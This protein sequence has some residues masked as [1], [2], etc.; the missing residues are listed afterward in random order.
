MR[1]ASPEVDSVIQPPEAPLDWIVLKIAQRCNLNCTYCYVYNRG[2]DSWK[3]RPPIISD[4]VVAALGR[5]I[6][7]QCEKY[8]LHRFV[9]EFHGG[10]PLLV[11]KKRMQSLIDAL[12][13]TCPSVHLRMIL[14]TNGVLLDEEWLALFERNQIGFGISL[15]GPPEL[16]D[17]HRVFLNGEGSTRRVLE[18][19]ERL[20]RA[21]PK[22]DQL[23]GGVLCVVDPS[24]NG[25]DLVRWFVKNGFPMFEFLLP[26]GNYANP[27][28]GW[29][30]VAPYRRFLL[31]AFDAW[32]AMGD[33][34]P[35]IRLFETMLLA[36]MGVKPQ[37]D[38]LGGDLRKLCVVE[39][40]GSIG[41]SDV[42]RFCQG[43]YS[44]DELNVF[45]NSFDER[46]DTYGIEELQQ[47]GAECQACPHLKSCGGGYLPHRYDGRS[48]ANPSIYCEALYA[49]GERMAAAIRADVPSSL[50]RVKPDSAA[51]VMP[52]ADVCI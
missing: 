50:V 10:E 13:A 48:F 24:V 25:G 4:E 5:R 34:A 14:Q 1:R 21:G 27:P 28:P 36:F 8:S 2:D 49:L 44:V 40:D 18:N 15:D 33:E 38:A 39:S 9:V 12:R 31:E 43:Q 16:A 29:T 30:G 35:Q 47:P 45:N 32:Y 51:G 42:M 6:A 22:F 23:L 3:Q 17:R 26:D 46:T 20:R 19:I 52:Q 11:G 7:E 41:V 37:L